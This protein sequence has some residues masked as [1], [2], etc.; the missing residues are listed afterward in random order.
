RY[1]GTRM[2]VFTTADGLPSNDTRHLL[3]DADGRVW[4]ATAAGGGRFDGSRFETILTTQDGLPTNEIRHMLEARDGSLWLATGDYALTGSGLGLVRIDREGAKTWTVADGLGH[5]F[6]AGIAQDAAGDIWLATAAGLTRIHDDETTT[7]TTEHGL[8]QNRL[9]GLLIDEDDIW[10]TGQGITRFRDDRFTTFTVADGLPV[11]YWFPSVL[12]GA[13]RKW[14]G[15]SGSLSRLDESEFRHFTATDGL[16]S[17]EILALEAGSENELW[18]ATS[19][20]VSRF[21]GQIFQS[22]HRRDGLPHHEARDLLVDRQGTVWI[23]TKAGVARYRPRTSPLTLHLSDVIADRGYGPVDHLSLPPEQRFLAFELSTD[24]LAHRSRAIV[25]RYRL[26]GHDPGWRQTRETRI[27]YRDLWSGSFTFEVEAIDRD[28]NRSSIVRVQVE[29]MPA[30]Y[31]DSSRFVPFLFL[32][33]T[34]GGGAAFVIR[35][36][37]VQRVEAAALRRRQLARVR[38]REAVWK[39]QSADDIEEVLR[40]VATGMQ[41]LDIPFDFFGVNVLTSDTPESV[42][43]YTMAATGAWHRRTSMSGPNILRFWRGGTTVYRR[44][45][46]R[47]DLYG[48]GQMLH[49]GLRCVVDIP[50]S[51]GTLAVSSSL[52]NAFSASD[53][54]TLEQLAR[55]LEEGFHRL[56]DLR[57]IE[58]RRL[59]VGE[60]EKRLTSLERVREVIW[61]LE[62]AHAPAGLVAVI[63]DCLEDLGV[64]LDVC[65]VNVVESQLPPRVRTYETRWGEAVEPKVEDGTPAARAII[66]FWR[67]QATVYRAD[68]HHDDP[69]GELI[70]LEE[71]GVSQLPRCILDIPFSHGTLAVNSQQMDAFSIQD[72]ENV[73][74]LAS[75]LS[76]GFRRI[77]DLHALEA[78]SAAEK[79]AR[80]AAEQA[81]R[82]KSVFLANMSHEIRTPMNAILGYAQILQGDEGLAPDQ[83]SALVTIEQSGNHLLG[84]INDVLDIS[85]IEAGHE[86]MNVVTFDLTALIE[87]MSGMFEV[88]CQQ[89]GLRWMLESEGLPANRVRGDERKLR[90]VL[91]NLLANAVKFTTQGQVLLRVQHGLEPDSFRFEVSDT[92]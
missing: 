75:L 33:L 81:S 41:E 21:D 2:S 88:R 42:D 78:Q 19:T 44:D 77:A 74:L 38:V 10:V 39:M 8:P 50:F 65:G 12:D 51:A 76:D 69:H 91:I 46:E 60:A 48:E 83:R 22:L 13:G 17:A 37:I 53:L 68:L 59:E 11:E 89:K 16:A 49:S 1:D 9:S 57:S 47:E 63:N 25:Y 45:L 66:D 71:A 7:F 79:E 34:L 70:V 90:Q 84:L 28:F 61:G 24:R 56:G 35:R 6:V 54:T 80:L 30:W 18:L 52:P 58:Q 67:R 36:G 55:V 3:E 32:L 62:D 43:V 26:T 23:A 82:A 85:K 15:G 92:G 86:E 27:E 29:A 5:D 40:S 72:R 20:G 73:E 64:E 31:S 4:V 14:F 87:T